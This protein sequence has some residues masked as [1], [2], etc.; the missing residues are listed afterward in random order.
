MGEQEALELCRAVPDE[1]RT[2]TEVLR[3]IEAIRVISGDDES[4]H[5]AEDRL[6][7]SVLTAIANGRNEDAAADLCAAAL[8]TLSVEFARWCA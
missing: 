1:V 2:V 8:Q 6:W 5:S 7:A 3:H 4:A